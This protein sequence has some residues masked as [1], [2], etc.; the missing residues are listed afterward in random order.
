[1]TSITACA[2]SAFDAYN[3]EIAGNSPVDVIVP[4]GEMAVAVGILRA[5][6][7]AELVAS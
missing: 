4:A 3:A 2:L 5:M 6:F 1:M 7:D